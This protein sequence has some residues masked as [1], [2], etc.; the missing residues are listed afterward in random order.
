MDSHGPRPR[1]RP[2]VGTLLKQWR[3]QRKL[4]QTGLALAAGVSTR[5]VGFIEVGRSAPSREMVLRLGEA[6]ELPLRECNLL[7]QAAGFA[8][9]FGPTDL[10]APEMERVRAAIEFILEKHEPNPTVLMDVNYNILMGNPSFEAALEFF[11]EG[12]LVGRQPLN[13]VRLLL[14][15]QGLRHTVVNAEAALGRMIDRLRR[16]V[17]SC[18]SDDDAQQLLEEALS[19]GGPH[20]HASPLPIQESPE[21]IVPL[22]LKRQDV[23]IRCFTVVT[24]LASVSDVTLQELQIESYFPADEQSE[25]FIRSLV[26]GPDALPEGRHRRI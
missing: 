23:E 4:S 13:F 24:T 19:L 3:A 2:P 18:P 11:V 7:L 6:L 21:L 22:H 26:A 15:E 5:H 20:L 25:Q 8:P 10:E 1:S 14:D 9:G 12:D 17:V 16:R